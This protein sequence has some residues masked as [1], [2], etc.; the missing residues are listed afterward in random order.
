MISESDKQSSSHVNY[1][2]VHNQIN[3]TGTQN[4]RA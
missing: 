3:C 2:Q 4:W 1:Q